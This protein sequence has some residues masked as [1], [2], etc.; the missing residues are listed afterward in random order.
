MRKTRVSV[1]GMAIAQAV[2][3]DLP[4]SDTWVF[5]GPHFW[6]SKNLTPD[7]TLRQWWERATELDAEAKAVFHEYLYDTPLFATSAS[8]VA[9]VMAASKRAEADRKRDAAG[10]FEIFA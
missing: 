4:L 1:P 7:A 10:A 8:I 5:A 9:E 6:A 3:L 2:R